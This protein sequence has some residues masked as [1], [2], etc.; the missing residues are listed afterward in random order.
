MAH[1]GETSFAY[2]NCAARAKVRLIWSWTLESGVKKYDADSYVQGGLLL[3]YDGIR[4]A[5]LDAPHSTNA[6]TWANL[7]S[8]GSSHDATK[9]HINQNKNG[10]WS[11]KGFD[12]RGADYF[13]AAG[14][15]DFGRHFSAQVVTDSSVSWRSTYKLEWP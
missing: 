15:A 12:F 10:E 6:T 13:K 8:L 1:D 14:T 3:N 2:T 11:A 9:T 7:G 4:N 5:G